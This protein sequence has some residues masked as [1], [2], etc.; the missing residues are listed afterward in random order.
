[1]SLQIF[2][3]SSPQNQ[4]QM[5]VS[6]IHSSPL[7]FI[8][9]LNPRREWRSR[10]GSSSDACVCPSLFFILFLQWSNANHILALAHVDQV[11]LGTALGAIMGTSQ[12]VL[13]H[14]NVALTLDDLGFGFSH[15]MRFSHRRGFV[16][17]QS[18]VAQ[19]IALVL[20]VMGIASTL[21]M[22]DLLAAFAA[23][24]ALPGFSLPLIDAL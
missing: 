22:D 2:D 4:L 15:L 7:P 20:F 18:Y 17:R 16:D 1:M 6:H 9:S 19:Y 3:T 5:T 13:F 14:A 21:G 23:G 11:V 10:S 12:R 24:A 8:L